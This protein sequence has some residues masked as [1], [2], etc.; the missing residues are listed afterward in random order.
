MLYAKK[1][2][3]YFIRRFFK[4]HLF[5]ENVRVQDIDIQLRA[6]KTSRDAVQWAKDRGY[7]NNNA[8]AEN[9]PMTLLSEVVNLHFLSQELG[10]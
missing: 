1:A 7:L 4:V 8:T 2:L 10:C 5:L 9:I 3:K 6:L